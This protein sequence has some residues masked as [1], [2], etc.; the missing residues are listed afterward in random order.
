MEGS[1]NL[2]QW[3]GKVGSV[4]GAVAVCAF[5]RG[6]DFATT[7]VAIG[8]GRAFEAEPFARH[9]LSVF[10]HHMGLITYEA[11]ITT[12]AIFLGCRLATRVFG[13]SSA[14]AP[15][16][17]SLGERMFFVSIGMISLIVAAFNVQYLI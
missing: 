17:T 14:G 8:R 9:V 7:W 3:C 2:R 12:P 13:N 4:T 1:T 11:M 15:V 16:G 10:G 5:G 6:L